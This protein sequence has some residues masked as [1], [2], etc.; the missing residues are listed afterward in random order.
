MSAKPLKVKKRRNNDAKLLVVKNK[1]IPTSREDSDGGR[2]TC[3]N[4][5]W[6]VEPSP[7]EIEKHNAWWE[8]TFEANV[9]SPYLLARLCA[10]F[11][12]LNIET[13]GQESYKITWFVAL[14]HKETNE[15]LTFYDYKGGASYGSTYGAE[16]SKSFVRDVRSLLKALRSDRFPHPYD[17]CVVGEIA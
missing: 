8:K 11:D 14:R 16:K 5:A 13:H 10:M 17:G 3:S 4:I 2:P 1:W 12:G 9:S 6:S 15:L 7:K